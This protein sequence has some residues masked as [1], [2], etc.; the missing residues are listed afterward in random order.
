MHT[1]CTTHSLLNPQLPSKVLDFIFNQCVEIASSVVVCQV[2]PPSVISP[3]LLLRQ[4]GSC[5]RAQSFLPLS[6]A[7]IVTTAAPALLALPT[8]EKPCSRGQQR[9]WPLAAADLGG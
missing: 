7:E 5:S 6:S 9:R 4:L 1:F 2:K 3:P 8:V